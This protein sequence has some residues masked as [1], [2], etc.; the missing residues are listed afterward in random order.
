[1]RPWSIRRSSPA[2]IT[3]ARSS[4]DNINLNIFADEPGDLAATPEQIAVHR[5]LAEQE[6]RLF[7]TQ[8]FDHYEFLLA[9]TD[10]LGGIGLEHLRSSENSQGRDYFTGWNAGSA[11]RDLLAHE[12]THS[13]NGK[14]RRPRRP[15]DAQ[16]Q[17]ADARQPALGL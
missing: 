10:E 12:S 14:Y 5:R 2:A 8:H 16:L 4:A 7:G 15:V 6:L 13:W 9:L 1:M 11:G 3:G 17:R